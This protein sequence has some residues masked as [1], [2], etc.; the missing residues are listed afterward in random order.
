MTS[1][2]AFLR[3]INVGGSK[4]I[5]M[6][7]LAEAIKALGFQN[8]K[9]LLA[10]GNVLF[11]ARAADTRILTQTLERKIKQT[12]GHDV[13]VVLRTR[14][15]LQRL[16]AADPF[17][18]IKVTPLTRLFVTFLSDTPKT[19]LKIPYQSPDKSFRILRLSGRD[20]CS[21]LTLG[22]QWARNLRQMDILEK[23][24][25]KRITTR[26]WSTVQKCALG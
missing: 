25:G 20:L 17:T 7:K 12:F 8:V 24:F 1:Y 15:A 9:T 19:I 23:E 6:A 14:R 13:S 18:G 5:R 11:E 3:G 21:V 26:S 16:L 4:K 10:S 22:P 2:V